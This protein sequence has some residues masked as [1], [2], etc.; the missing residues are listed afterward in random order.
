MAVNVTLDGSRCI[1]YYIFFIQRV[2]RAIFRPV[3]GML[4]IGGKRAK[5]HFWE[6]FCQNLHEKHVSSDAWGNL[7]LSLPC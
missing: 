4:V 3:A 6:Y 7:P 2:R 1:T 5:H